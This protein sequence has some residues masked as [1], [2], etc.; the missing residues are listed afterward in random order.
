MATVFLPPALDVG[1]IGRLKG[2][3]LSLHPPVKGL[4]QLAVNLREIDVLSRLSR[5]PELLN[6]TTHDCPPVRRISNLRYANI[7]YI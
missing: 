3:F 4:N 2:S 5:K 6:K 1:L 7:V